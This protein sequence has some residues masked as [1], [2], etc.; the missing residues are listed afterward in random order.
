MYPLEVNRILSYKFLFPFQPSAIQGIEH[1]MRAIRLFLDMVKPKP[2]AVQ[3]LSRTKYYIFRILKYAENRSAT[4]GYFSVW[5]S[6][7]RWLTNSFACIVTTACACV[8]LSVC[9][10]AWMRWCLSVTSVY[11]I[12]KCT[13]KTSVVCRLNSMCVIVGAASTVQFKQAARQQVN[14]F[15]LN[16]Y[17]VNF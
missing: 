16:A 6:R 8:V 4:R 2:T 5:V 11:G 15:S 9:Q 3:I 1:R 14:A 12:I 17:R 10:C 7:V 13:K